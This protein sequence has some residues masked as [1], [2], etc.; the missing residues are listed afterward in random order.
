MSDSSFAIIE[1]ATLPVVDRGTGVTTRTLVH[2][3]IGS[4]HLTNGITRFDPG[5]QVA[6]HFHNCDESV[7]VIEGEAIFD[8]DGQTFTMKAFDATLVRAG[9]PHRFTNRTDKPVA[10]FWT[11]ATS[12]VTRTFSESGVTVEIGSANDRA[13]GAKAPA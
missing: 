2:K 6:M 13:G 4:E 3:G 10:I 8:V 9:T 1:Y 12:Y 7:V 11:Y 5:S